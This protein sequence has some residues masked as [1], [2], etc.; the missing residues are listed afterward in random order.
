MSRQL[1]LVGIGEQDLGDGATALQIND[2]QH[3]VRQVGGRILLRTQ[4]DGRVA[5]RPVG[6][7]HYSQPDG[8]IAHAAA[9]R[10]RR[11]FRH[12]RSGFSVIAEVPQT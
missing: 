8:K 7:G 12:G 11:P 6:P 2:R 10:K 5:R 3:V 1:S 4:C 9:S